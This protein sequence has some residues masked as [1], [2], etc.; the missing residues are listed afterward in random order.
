MRGPIGPNRPSERHDMRTRA[1]RIAS[2]DGFV[3]VT[4]NS[5]GGSGS[6]ARSRSEPDAVSLEGRSHNG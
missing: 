4:P 1:E 3:M 6:P 2:L 5:V